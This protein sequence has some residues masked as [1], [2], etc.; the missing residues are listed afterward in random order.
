ML[1]LRQRTGLYENGGINRS[2]IYK[3]STAGR[4][5]GGSTIASSCEMPIYMNRP[6]NG[7]RDFLYK[8]IKKYSKAEILT[9]YLNNS[10]AMGLG[11]EDH[12]KNISGVSTA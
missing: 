6:S 10:V 9:M 2:F 7:E 8:S 5:G 3:L 11:V 12:L 1:S 4:S